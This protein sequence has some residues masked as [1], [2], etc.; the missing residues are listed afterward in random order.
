M[1]ILQ[2]MSSPKAL[3][4]VNVSFH[5]GI[6]PDIDT[7]NV[8]QAGHSRVIKECIAHV[9]SEGEVVIPSTFTCDISDMP[10]ARVLPDGFI[11]L[12]GSIEEVAQLVAH[13]E[14]TRIRIYTTCYD[15]TV[16]P[17]NFS[18][19][20]AKEVI[21]CPTRKKESDI[22]PSPKTLLQSLHSP[23]EKKEREETTN[24]EPT[25]LRV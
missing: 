19:F 7:Q 8:K 18:S 23:E 12:K 4:G 24:K 16:F 11:A 1:Y 10:Y 5:K 22:R 17:T 25:L 20:S 2:V 3:S 13:I 21:D 9:N 15:T 14:N 6:W